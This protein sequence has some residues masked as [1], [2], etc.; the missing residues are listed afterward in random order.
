[1]LNNIAKEKNCLTQKRGIKVIQNTK[2]LQGYDCGEKV[3]LSK[4][5]WNP[6]RRM[7]VTTHFSEIIKQP[8]FLKSVKIQ[9]VYGNFFPNLSSMISKKC[10]VTPNFLFGFW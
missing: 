5:Y 10:V 2:F 4:D 1:M 8:L 6:K 3:D 9:R 7:W